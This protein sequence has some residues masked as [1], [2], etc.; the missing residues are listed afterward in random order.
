MEDMKVLHKIID[1]EM[2]VF[3]CLSS[4]ALLG[5]KDSARQSRKSGQNLRKLLKEWRA[6]SVKSEKE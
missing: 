1:K 3:I 4:T 2:K 6:M 5:N